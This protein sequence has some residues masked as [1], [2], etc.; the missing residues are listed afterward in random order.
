MREI[1]CSICGQGGG[2]Q[3]LRRIGPKKSGL[4]THVRCVM[5]AEHR[6]WAVK[7]LEEFNKAVAEQY[8]EG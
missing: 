6:M 4:Y 1:V 7:R 8:A 5:I 2:R 3:P